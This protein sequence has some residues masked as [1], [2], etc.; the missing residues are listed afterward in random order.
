MKIEY[1][2]QTGHSHHKSARTV[3]SDSVWSPDGK[4]LLVLVAFYDGT[5]PL[6]K[7]SSELVLITLP[8]S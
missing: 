6:S 5:D 3:V 4:S 8:D 7:G 2:V 1:F